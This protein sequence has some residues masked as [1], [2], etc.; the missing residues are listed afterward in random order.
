MPDGTHLDPS[1]HDTS[2]HGTYDHLIH[3]LDSPS[4]DYRLIDHE[5]EGATEAVRALPGRPA[6]EAAK[7]IALRV[8]V[9]RRTTRHVL[10]LVSGD[11]RV[12]LDAVRAM[13]AASRCGSRWTA[14]PHATSSCSS[15]GTGG[16]AW[17]P[18]G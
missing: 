2:R 10:V 16:W 17:T 12:G 8:K 11:R 1:P 18:S 7:C 14:A 3:L 5:P 6:C 15:P 4:V 13:L 9:D